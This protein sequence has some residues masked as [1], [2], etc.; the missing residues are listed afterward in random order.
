MSE[1]PKHDFKLH[2]KGTYLATFLLWRSTLE[3]IM[4]S[5]CENAF[6]DS[7][8]NAVITRRKM[9]VEN[10]VDFMMSQ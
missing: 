3:T 2:L 10:T 5:G 7:I 9:A 6:D 1:E 4:S 8:K